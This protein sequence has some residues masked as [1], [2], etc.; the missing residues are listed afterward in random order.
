MS[1]INTRNSTRVNQE[2]DAFKYYDDG[3]NEIVLLNLKPGE[4]IQE[5]KNPLFHALE[6]RNGLPWII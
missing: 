4:E 3:C 6:L 1:K 2:L 5:H